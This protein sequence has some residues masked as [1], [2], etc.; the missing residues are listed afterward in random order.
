VYQSGLVDTKTGFI[1]YILPPKARNSF[2][3]GI[4][5]FDAGDVE[6]NFS[7]GEQR[8]VC[9]QKDLLLTL[10]YG[11][12]INKYFRTGIALKYL[13]STL[14]DTYTDSTVVGDFGILCGASLNGVQCGLV[15]QNIGG[16]LKYGEV[17]DKL[18]STTKFEINYTYNFELYDVFESHKNSINSSISMVNDNEGVTNILVGFEYVRHLLCAFRIGYQTN[19]DISMMSLGAGFTIKGNVF[20]DYSIELARVFS[21]IHKLSITKKY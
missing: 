6:L 9:A 1:G 3:V 8:K 5:Y 13:S 4:G 16:S 15:M 14:A 7:N 11:Y 19:S 21:P 10:N 12:S 18:Y 2:G 20:I 17:S